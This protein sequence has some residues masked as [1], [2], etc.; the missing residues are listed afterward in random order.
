MLNKVVLMYGKSPYVS[1][2]VYSEVF[3]TLYKVVFESVVEILN[4]D[5]VINSY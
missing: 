3:I 5:Q 4:C 1:M 2:T